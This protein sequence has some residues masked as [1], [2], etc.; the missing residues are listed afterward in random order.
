MDEQTLVSI[1]CTWGG[2]AM[3]TVARIVAANPYLELPMLKQHAAAAGLTNETTV[4][5]YAGTGP[6]ETSGE[7]NNLR[8][9]YD[10]LGFGTEWESES[11]NSG[12]TLP[13]CEG[14]FFVD[15]A[16]PRW[17]VFAKTSYAARDDLILDLPLIAA[18]HIATNIARGVTIHSC[19]GSNY[20]FQAAN[21]ACNARS[22]QLILRG[23]A[24]PRGTQ[25]RIAISIPLLGDIPLQIHSVPGCEQSNTIEEFFES[26]LHENGTQ[27]HPALGFAA[28][29]G[30]NHPNLG[31]AP[32]I[33]S[34][35]DQRGQA[36]TFI[37]RRLELRSEDG[38]LK[39]AALKVSVALGVG[40]Q[41]HS[42]G[43]DLILPDSNS[44]EAS[45]ELGASRQITT[46]FK[47]HGS[48][49]IGTWVTHVSGLVAG[50]VIASDALNTSIS[51]SSIAFTAKT[52]YFIDS[53]EVAANEENQVTVVNHSVEQPPSG[54]PRADSSWPSFH[55]ASGQK[56]LNTPN[57]LS[58]RPPK[59]PSLPIELQIAE[60][61]AIAHPHKRSEYFKMV[62][63]ELRRY[64]Y[65]LGNVYIKRALQALRDGVYLT[66]K[67]AEAIWIA[68]TKTR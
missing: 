51:N 46:V 20:E 47:T 5:I 28:L 12:R 56:P 66:P 41:V 30:F 17:I 54:S 65:P 58:M 23:A 26:L 60:R 35:D 63:Q 15:G 48:F 38:Y 49:P 9:V 31:L 67:E 16:L 43:K 25:S 52:R 1:S 32:K 29:V 11:A 45:L 18:I 22:A 59:K 44:P 21:L 6:W 19:F 14:A 40:Q 55:L 36:L 3:A 39:S 53:N 57:R 61:A 42:D 33:E 7:G 8:L 50:N 10:P 37:R 27:L 64:I 34:S 62:Y 2:S 13:T 4:D 68:M 24:L